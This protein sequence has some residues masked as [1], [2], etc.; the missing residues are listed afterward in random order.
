MVDFHEDEYWR[1]TL[2]VCFHSLSRKIW[3]GFPELRVLSL[4]VRIKRVVVFW[5]LY[6]SLLTLGNYHMSYRPNS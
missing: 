3:E 5:R 1:S 6:W 2:G 4:Q